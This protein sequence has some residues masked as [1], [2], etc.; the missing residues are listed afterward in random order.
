ML[1]TEQQAT[2]KK[3]SI[4]ISEHL[5]EQNITIPG[6]SIRLSIPIATNDSGNLIPASICVHGERSGIKINVSE[7][8]I[9]AVATCDEYLAKVQVL[10]RTVESYEKETTALNTT[11]QSREK[12]ISVLK[13]EKSTLQKTLDGIKKTVKTGI[14][15]AAVISIVAVAFK[16]GKPILLIIKKLF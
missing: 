12:D 7:N 14:I 9:Q 4:R 11:V 6:D 5:T 13:Q 15:I 8:S 2:E 10:E 3:D 1:I 16:Y